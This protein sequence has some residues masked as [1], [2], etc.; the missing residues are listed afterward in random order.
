MPSASDYV[1]ESVKQ[2]AQKVAEKA[3]TVG[4]PIVAVSENDD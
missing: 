2:S 3:Y 1:P 4:E